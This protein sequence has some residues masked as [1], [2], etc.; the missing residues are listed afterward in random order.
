[1]QL[2]RRF[3]LYARVQNTIL[4]ILLFTITTLIAWLST[5]YV[6]QIDL[7]AN[8]RYTLSQRSQ[9]LLN[10][11]SEPLNITAYTSNNALLRNSIKKLVLRYQ[12]YKKD[13]Q[14]EFIDPFTNPTETR[15][16][17]IQVD[18]E[19]VITYQHRR[20]HTQE[21]S[22]SAV[23]TALQRLIR[24]ESH[25]IVFLQGHGERNP[26]EFQNQQHVGLWSRNLIGN[27]FDVQ[28]LNLSQ[29][30]TISDKISL[31]IIA[32]PQVALIPEEIA[33]IINYIKRGG[34]LLWLLEPDDKELRGLLPLADE[35]GITAQ[36]GTIIDPLSSY[37]SI[38]SVTEYE[39]HPI[40]NDISYLNTFFPEAAGLLYQPKN[41]WQM[42]PLIIT[43]DKTWLESGEI[44]GTIAFDQNHDIPGPLSLAFALNRHIQLANNKTH[45][46]RIVVMG[47][48]D[49]VSNAF[50]TYAGNLNLAMRLINWLVNDDQ[51]IEIPAIN[52]IDSELQLTENTA[53]FIGIFFL[54]ALPIG[55]IS[56]GIFVWARR[57]K[58]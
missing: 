46:Q 16:N 39:E 3:R 51:L 6:Y 18:G 23:S 19:L 10:Q 36:T 41:D 15:E 26:T 24:Q 47:D 43:H 17:N 20:E 42:S 14:L 21:L 9:K 50:L 27:G 1:M 30:K 32:S 5:R 52:N 48:G 56:T 22:E 25:Q 11:L 2:T 13:I 58:A 12:I 49:F 54:F 28:T 37:P 34:N 38:T 4:L 53:Y 57:R 29:N 31:L 55:L 8:N 33:I 40:T 35:L 7:T 44:K 45:L